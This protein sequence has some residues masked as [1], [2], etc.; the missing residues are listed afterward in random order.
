[1]SRGGCPRTSA[2]RLRYITY[3]RIETFI[4]ILYVECN[5][6]EDT[7]YSRRDDLQDFIYDYHL[8][9]EI[10]KY[11]PYHSIIIFMTS[12]VIVIKMLSNKDNIRY[13]YFC[14]FPLI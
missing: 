5:I 13:T 8:E 4:I 10:G 2:N 14:E 7:R 11:L 1:M 12:I 6:V 3:I 9:V